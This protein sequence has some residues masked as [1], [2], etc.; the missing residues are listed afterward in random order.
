[1]KTPLE[2]ISDIFKDMIN[3]PALTPDKGKTLHETAWDMAYKRYRQTDNNNQALS[4]MP[5]VPKKKKSDD[6]D[7]V[8][9]HKHNSSID[10][11]NNVHEIVKSINKTDIQ[12]I[13][14]DVLNLIKAD[15][16]SARSRGLV[17]QSGNW[18]K[19]GRWVRPESESEDYIY[20]DAEADADADAFDSA[21]SESEAPNDPSTTETKDFSNMNINELSQTM[22]SMAKELLNLRMN[23]N[24][25]QKDGNSTMARRYYDDYH[26]LKNE[27][28]KAREYSDKYFRANRPT[29]RS[30]TP[31]TFR[32]N[33]PSSY[34]TPEGRHPSKRN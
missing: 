31:P 33:V 23:F 17:P 6:T 27:Y 2:K 32:E 34:H 14:F 1:M 9:D 29:F 15:A 22:N 12:T 28:E 16:A 3:N 21:E 30:G 10:R 8:D 19:P 11:G 25:A 18:E 20:D 5:L 24:D 4:L 7:D 26:S 13:A